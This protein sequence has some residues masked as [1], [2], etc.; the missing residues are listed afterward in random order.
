VEGPQRDK[1]LDVYRKR[2]YELDPRVNCPGVQD[3]EALAELKS[4]VEKLRS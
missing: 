3:S 1:E 4:L 2:C